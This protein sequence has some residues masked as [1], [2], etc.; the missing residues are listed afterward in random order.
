MGVPREILRRAGRTPVW[1]VLLAVRMYQAVVAPL[2]IGSCKFCPTCSEYMA[3]AV[4]KHGAV[5]GL[6]L[7]LRRVLRC[8]PFTPGGIDPVP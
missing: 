1:G 6:G 7:G 2:L 3:E 4:Q 5:R 8:H